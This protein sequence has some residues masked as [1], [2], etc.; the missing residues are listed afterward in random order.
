MPLAKQIGTIIKQSLIR[1]LKDSFPD[2]G[3]DYFLEQEK[4]SRNKYTG[5]ETA[6]FKIISPYMFQ[7][8]KN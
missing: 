3:N 8:M 6:M 1:R 7:Y 4:K 5:N 2:S